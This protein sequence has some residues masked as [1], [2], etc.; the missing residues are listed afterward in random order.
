MRDKGCG[1]RQATWLFVD[2]KETFYTVVAGTGKYDGMVTTRTLEQL[3]PFKAIKE[4]T[5]QGCNH[6]TGTYKL[7]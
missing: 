7:K 2:G 1:R 6:Q 3:G 5:F 4:G